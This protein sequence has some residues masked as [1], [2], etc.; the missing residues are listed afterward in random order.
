MLNENTGLLDQEEEG[1]EIDVSNV[2]QLK[3]N[4]F[5]AY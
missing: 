1:S 5:R 4:L 3:L 2:L